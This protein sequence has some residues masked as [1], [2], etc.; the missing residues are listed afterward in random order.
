MRIVEIRSIFPYSIRIWENTDQ[1]KLFIWTFFTQWKA[2]S[3]N[4][5]V[6]S[7]FYLS[8]YIYFKCLMYLMYVWDISRFCQ[9]NF[10]FICVCGFNAI[11]DQVFGY[12]RSSHPKLFWEVVT[13]KIESNFSTLSWAN[14]W[15][16][17][18]DDLPSRNAS[19][20]LT[21]SLVSVWIFEKFRAVFPKPN[22]NGCFWLL[23][24][25]WKCMT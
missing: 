17:T 12:M 19:K 18:E 8:I 16:L 5:K 2:H 25:Q 15:N 13:L 20:S 1:K 23:P 22:L 7:E 24:M 10:P 3:G 4:W 6:H 11:F 9:D 14:L 21:N